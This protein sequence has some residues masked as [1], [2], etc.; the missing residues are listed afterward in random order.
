MVM[1]G[2]L[3]LVAVDLCQLVIPKIIQKTLDLLSESQFTQGIILAN[4]LKILGLAAAMVILRFFWRLCIVGPSRKIETQIRQ[5]IFSHLMSLSFS[6]FNK[7]KTGDIMALCIND[8]NAIRMASGMGLIGLTD[9]LFMGSMSIVFMLTTDVPLTLITI[10]PMPLI[11]F[12][13]LR[14][15]GMIQSKFKDV[16]E[17]F[18]TIS[19][20]SQEAF[21]GIRVIKGF[22]QEEQELKDFVK[23]CD[24]YVDKNMGLVKLWGF[25]FPIIS[26]LACISVSLLFYFGGLSVL[27]GSLSLGKFMSFSFYIGLLVWPMMAIGWVFNMLQR[28]IASSKRIMELLET[29]SDVHV[30]A[31]ADIKPQ[32]NGTIAGSIRFDRCTFRY[33]PDGRDI[34]SNVS[35]HIKQGTSCGIMGKPGSG[36][37]TLLSLLFHLFPIAEN[38]IRIDEADINDIPLSALR[39]AIGYV[40]QDSFLFSDTIANNIAFGT[41][42]E[43]CMPQAIERVAK[44]AAIH[45][46]I[47]RFVNGYD[48]KIGERGITLSGGQKQRIAIA[49]A[50]LIAPRILVLDDALS[51][52]DAAT[53]QKILKSII[54]AAKGITSIIVAHRVSTVMHCDRIVVLDEGKII[55]QGT[56][57]QLA[58]AEG[59]Y[60]RLFHL[61]KLSEE[62]VVP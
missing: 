46:E 6:Y 49:R 38:S 10:L 29:R 57:E 2:M 31:I 17:S 48:T 23:A 16:Q 30:S 43:N 11:V 3:L 12:I 7:T 56:H 58:A 26:F 27:H 54:S 37:T 59:F 61:Q 62:K 4:A 40:P 19:S 52:V 28:G 20:K 55:E 21:S 25:F 60:A 8:L 36:K 14:F 45:D 9:A 35:L 18:G 34:I 13:M 33:E 39:S 50:L 47:L 44:L 53:E 5:D 1:C 15:G 22:V 24:E 42:D 51:S 41:M 32:K